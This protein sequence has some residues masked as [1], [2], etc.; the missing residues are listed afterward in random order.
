MTVK[1][2]DCRRIRKIQ[3]SFSL[4]LVPKYLYFYPKTQ[5]YFIII[6]FCYFIIIRFSSLMSFIVTISGKLFSKLANLS[7]IKLTYTIKNLKVGFYH[8]LGV[9]VYD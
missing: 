6:S 2:S 7:L 8:R 1:V 4:P 5:L 9:C 3:Q